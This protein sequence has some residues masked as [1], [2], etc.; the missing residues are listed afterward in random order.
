MDE[1]QLV[2]ISKFLSLI[3]RHRP[4]QIGLTLDAQG[5]A[6]IAELIEG[7]QQHQVFLTREQI[8]QV[9]AENDKQRFVLSEDETRIRARQGHSVSVD[10][11]LTAQ[12][13]PATLYHGTASRFLT[14]IRA[15][16]LQKGNRHHVHL[17]LDEETARKVGTRHGVPV[18][19]QIRARLMWQEGYAFFLS[20]NGVWL[21]ETVPPAY[22]LFP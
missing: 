2:R 8:R 5:W 3:L 16:G 19:L 17:S 12:E 13:P 11:G 1:K 15:N 9:V 6:N 18:V 7:A 14:S 20:E 4:E 21:T 22:L 10:L